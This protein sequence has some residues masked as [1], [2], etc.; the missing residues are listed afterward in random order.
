MKK[1]SKSHDGAV[2]KKKKK[3]LHLKVDTV[4]KFVCM[5]KVLIKQDPSF[6]VRMGLLGESQSHWKK[7]KT[8]ECLL[9]PLE[10]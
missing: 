10:W 6:I 7:T 3:M 4:Q 8:S 1:E 2:K 9:A 5:V